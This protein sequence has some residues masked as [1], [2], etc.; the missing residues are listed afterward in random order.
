VGNVGA[1]W[2]IADLGITLG[3]YYTPPLTLTSTFTFCVLCAQDQ[4]RT[5]R[6]FLSGLTPR[7][8]TDDQAKTSADVPGSD[9][10][11]VAA[12]RGEKT[13][14]PIADQEALR[15]LARPDHRHDDYGDPEE[16][17]SRIPGSF[18]TERQML[19]MEYLL[20][21]SK[22]SPADQAAAHGRLVSLFESKR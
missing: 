7:R 13:V 9:A 10:S 15:L 1:P 6:D 11:F 19:M 20:A 22:L 8:R 4:S 3:D 2:Q 5:V 14:Q 12:V 18:G 16:I 21:A 17:L